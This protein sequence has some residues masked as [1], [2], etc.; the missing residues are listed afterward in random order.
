MARTSSRAPEPSTPDQRRR[1]RPSARR[2]R[3]SRNAPPRWRPAAQPQRA[4]VGAARRERARVAGR[5]RR[6]PT[7]VAGDVLGRRSSPS[8]SRGAAAV[9]D[10]R[11]AVGVLARARS[12]G[13]ETSITMRPASASACMRRKSSLDSSVGQRRVRLVEE[14]HARVARERARDLGALLDRERAVAERPVARRR[15]CRA[16]RSSCA[17]AARRRPARSQP[18]SSRPTTMFSADGQVREQLRLL[19]HD[20][21]AVRADSP[22]T[23]AR[24]RRRISPVVAVASPAR[25]LTIVLLPAPF[26]PA[27]PRISPGRA[28][29]SRPS[30]ATRVAVALAQAA[31]A[32]RRR[33]SAAHA[34]RARRRAREPV[35]HD[36]ADRDGAEQES[37][38]A[39][40]PG[41]DQREAVGEHG[42]QQR[43]ASASR[44]TLPLPPARLG[45]ADDH[46][47][48][49]REQ[50]DWPSFGLAEPMNEKSR[51]AGQA[52]HARRR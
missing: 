41:R 8:S 2:G 30:S 17:L 7:S 47:G 34:S 38:E 11:D 15:G 27:T 35:E 18:C 21:D 16:R 4:A 42:E 26:G 1:S 48:E 28:S 43:A 5:R 20:G 32:R 40:G 9:E 23:T 12:A 3:G 24:R 44:S 39:N 29:R 19:V 31:D 50:V 14:Q 51:S 36:R 25:I 49:H 13:G 52:G 6:R 46:R 22:A 45:A 33:R 37:A 10:H